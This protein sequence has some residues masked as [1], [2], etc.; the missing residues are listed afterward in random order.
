MAEN[1][2]FELVT[3]SALVMSEAAEMVVIPGAE[4]DLGILP[5]HSPLIATLRP[6]ILDIYEGGKS[7]Q[8]IFVSG[9]VCEVQPEGCTILADEVLTENEITRASAEKR[10]VKAKKAL[11][12]TIAHAENFREVKDAQ[13][14]LA[15]AK[16]LMSIA[17]K[18][19]KG[20]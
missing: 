13:K 6:G 8:R 9:G 12:D 1:I 7:M 17:E 3:P 11:E 15:I 4:G 10:L 18:V 5:N 2:E 19:G 20:S 14:R 16:E